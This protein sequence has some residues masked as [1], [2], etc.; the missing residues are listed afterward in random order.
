MHVWE[1]PLPQRPPRDHWERV[2]DPDSQWG[3]LGPQA[4]DRLERWLRGDS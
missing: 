1:P 3:D 4:R 2:R